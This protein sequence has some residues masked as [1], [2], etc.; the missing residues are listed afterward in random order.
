M[1]KTLLILFLLP[2]IVVAQVESP[3]SLALGVAGVI[4]EKGSIDI[5]VLAQLISEKQATLKKEFIKK[6]MF[7]DLSNH[8]YVL[9]E[10]MY[11]SMNVLL[12]SD[13]KEAIKKNLLQNSAD[14]ALVFGFCELYLQL[15]N[16]MCNPKLD[17]L[18]KQYDIDYTSA[19]NLTDF[20]C[21]K[22]QKEYS[23]QL[24]SLNKYTTKVGTEDIRFSSFFIDLVFDVLKNDKEV[25]GT[26]GFLNNKLPLGK[27]FYEYH[28]AYYKVKGDAKLAPLVNALYS[29]VKGEVA[30]L[31]DNFILIKKL[32]QSDQSLDAMIAD[33]KSRI[34]AL[35]TEKSVVNTSSLAI[36]LFKKLSDDTKDVYEK[37]QSINPSNRA[38]T[39]N[40]DAGG[41]TAIAIA[42]TSTSN[43]E[44]SEEIAKNLSAFTRFLGK[45][46]N[47]TQYDLYYLENSI[48][49]LL[50]RLVTENGFDSKYLKLAEDFDVLITGDLLETL[51][52]KL[53]NAKLVDVPSAKISQFSELLELITRLDELDKV[54]TYQYVLK[55]IQNAGDIFEDR[56]LGVYINT[57]VNNLNT[58]TILNSEDNKVEVAV[59]DIITRVYEKYG[60]RQSSLFSLYFSIGASQSISSD[61]SYETLLPDSS[62][63]STTN[64]KS[65][66]FAGEKI[67]LK[68]K[69]IDFKWRNSFTVGESFQPRLRQKTVHVN[70]FR[71]ADPIVSD[72]F[73]VAYGSGILYKMANLTTQE[74]FKDPIA[75]IGLGI[76]FFNSLDLNIG[77]NWPLQAENDFFTSFEK[78]SM[79][80]ISFDVKIT[81][82]LAALGRKRKNKE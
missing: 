14:L 34:A 5:D 31:L 42:E 80:T 72:I 1:K 62:G 69:L 36:D 21:P 44:L 73:L 59:E 4:G 55:I 58:Y 22:K 10:Y 30:V 60:N 56:K 74:E 68:V 8:N 43:K 35:A 13:S 23:I 12:E 25:T 67:G 32:S 54:E 3:P 38:T 66:S 33:Y 57:L 70:K 81:D 19:S 37:L 71:S 50:V 11:S 15:A 47:F 41:N 45:G 28:S 40:P 16:T 49:P 29:R 18:L 77:Y 26:L 20:A 52:I 65:L 53:I 63:F 78:Q 6:S 46:A 39:T 64:V 51:R 7:N 61:F 82:Y 24:S 27:N 17:D 79:W 48:T 76:A 75:G 9:W 2:Q